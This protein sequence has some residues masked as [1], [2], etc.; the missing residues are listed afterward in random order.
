MTKV[1]DMKLFL[2]HWVNTRNILRKNSSSDEDDWIWM[3]K[4][5]NALHVRENDAFLYLKDYESSCE[6]EKMHD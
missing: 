2:M 3:Q 5:R 4:L 1:T 6:K